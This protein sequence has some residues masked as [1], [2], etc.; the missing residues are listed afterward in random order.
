MDV[1]L[2][3]DDSRAG[4]QPARRSAVG[5]SPSKPQAP[6]GSGTTAGSSSDPCGCRNFEACIQDRSDDGRSREGKD[7]QYEGRDHNRNSE[8]RNLLDSS[9]ELRGARYGER[10]IRSKGGPP[11]VGRKRLVLFTNSRDSVDQ[12]GDRSGTE[13]ANAPGYSGASSCAW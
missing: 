11:I 6:W 13:V 2:W 4:R 9:F 12:H 10:D 1:N 8:S 3:H 5:S 7:H